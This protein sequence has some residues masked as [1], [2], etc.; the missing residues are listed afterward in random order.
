MNYTSQPAPREAD[1][2]RP[3]SYALHDTPFI[4]LMREDGRFHFA[5]AKF[6]PS[7]AGVRPYKIEWR[8]SFAD[9]TAFTE[10]DAKAI[11]ARWPHKCVAIEREVVAA[12]LS[13]GANA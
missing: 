12:K 4:V 10:E 5:R 3:F 9:A 1:I 13:G 11:A 6:Q 7:P 8:T 2:Y